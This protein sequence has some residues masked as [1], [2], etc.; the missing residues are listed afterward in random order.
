MIEPI[1]LYTKDKVMICKNDIIEF[2]CWDSDD[3]IYW[4]F[5]YLVLDYNTFVYL[6]NLDFGSTIGKVE[7]RDHVII[8][9]DDEDI[10]MK[11][12]NLVGHVR[13]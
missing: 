12:F 9:M 11:G 4:E 13:L 5:K 2:L 3:L 8:E 1:Y 7:T 6:G 10:I